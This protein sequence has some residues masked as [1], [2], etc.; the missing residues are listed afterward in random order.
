MRYLK[1]GLPEELY[2]LQKDPEEL[3]NLAADAAHQKDLLRIREV[4]LKELRRTKAGY[5]EALPEIVPL[6]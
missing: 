1:P 2:D 4:A 5:S 3:T 6:R